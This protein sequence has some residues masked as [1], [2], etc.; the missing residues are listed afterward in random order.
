VRR[1]R[2]SSLDRS[3]WTAAAYSSTANKAS[4]ED[5]TFSVRE[6]EPRERCNRT[7]RHCGA[8]LSW[9]RHAGRSG[10]RI[11][12]EA[13]SEWRRGVRWRFG[14]VLGGMLLLAVPALLVPKV[15]QLSAGMVIGGVLGMAM[16]VWDS[17]PTFIENWR[18][19]RDGER[20]TEKELKPLQRDG[21][22]VV[23][24]RASGFYDTNFDHVVV[25]PRGVFLLDTKNRWGTFA[26]ED[27]VLSCHHHSAPQ[28]DYSMPKLERQMMGAAGGLERFLNERVG[29]IIDVWPVVVLWAGFEAREG[30]IGKV[31]IV[32]GSQLEAWLRKQPVRIAGAD[33]VTIAATV[34]SLPPAA[35]SPSEPR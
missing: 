21:W 5:E 15:G 32:H 35:H 20:W 7:V 3:K 14:L 13:R 34:E 31:Q 29:W 2:A 8:V 6:D 12:K 27:R 28:S 26:I 9:R 30:T 25:G 23:H 17:P 24:D 33:V 10:G 18:M 11:F 19:G 22:R 4:G 16:W 1:Q